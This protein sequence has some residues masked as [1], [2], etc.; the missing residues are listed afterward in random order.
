[1]A[2]K[3]MFKTNAKQNKMLNDL[4]IEREVLS[5]M[6]SPFCVNLHYA[7]QDDKELSLVLTLM[8][9]GDLGAAAPPFA[10]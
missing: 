7:Y 9:G 4:L 8:P 2:T 1:M 5:K 3:K 6:T 10:S